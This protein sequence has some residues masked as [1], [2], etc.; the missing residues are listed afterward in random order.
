MGAKIG[1]K[2]PKMNQKRHAENDADFGI[3]FGRILKQVSLHGVLAG[4]GGGTSPPGLALI[5]ASL[6]YNATTPAGVGGLFTQSDRRH[7]LTRAGE[8]WQGKAKKLASTRHYSIE[9]S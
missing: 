3:D 6:V 2:S 9:N 8:A 5:L 4:G 7:L 1:Q